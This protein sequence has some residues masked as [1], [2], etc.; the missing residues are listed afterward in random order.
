MLCY[1][2]TSE[3]HSRCYHDVRN[4]IFVTNYSSKMPF[5]HNAPTK[6]MYNKTKHKLVDKNPRFVQHVLRKHVARNCKSANTP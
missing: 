2:A 3:K 5:I 1:Q 4:K 6:K